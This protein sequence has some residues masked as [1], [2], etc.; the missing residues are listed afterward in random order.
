MRLA[1]RAELSA[2]GFP[3]FAG[4]EA[5]RVASDRCWTYIPNGRPVGICGCRFLANADGESYGLVWLMG[6]P[7]I[8]AHPVAAL[9]HTKKAFPLLVEGCDIS[10]NMVDSCNRT[11][12]RWVQWLGYELVGEVDVRGRQFIRFEQRHV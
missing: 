6:T 11:Y 5:S 3:P 4:L 1:D 2:M 8:S 9:R 10:G 12:V 7:D